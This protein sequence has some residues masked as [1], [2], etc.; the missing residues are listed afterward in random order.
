MKQAER[1]A[2]ARL[3]AERDGCL[4][5]YIGTH[6]PV[7]W[8]T[9]EWLIPFGFPWTH[10][11]D[12][13]LEA[14]LYDRMLTATPS[15]YARETRAAGYVQRFRGSWARQLQFIG[16]RG[17]KLRW[18]NP[19]LARR[20]VTGD[21]HA[22]VAPRLVTVD[23]LPAV[24]AIAAADLRAVEVPNVAALQQRLAGGWLE[25]ESL[26]HVP[27]LGVFEME[28]RPPWGEVRLFYSTPEAD[29]SDGLWDAL[30]GVARLWGASETY[31]ALEERESARRQQLTARGFEDVD[32]GVYLVCEL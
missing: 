7:R 20:V 5:G 1:H 8:D 28:V 4:V 16:D 3:Y 18:R 6:P 21:R 27:G 14:E 22:E 11:V 13:A 9:G 19:I 31:L 29:A 15:V 23:D 24:C 10:P 25:L 2:G 26:W 12:P 32:A 17:W 30:D